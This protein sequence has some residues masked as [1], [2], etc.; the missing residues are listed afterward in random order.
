[1][2]HC[3]NS[4]DFE[5]ETVTEETTNSGRKLGFDGLENDD[6]REVLNAHLE[7]FTDDGLLILDQQRESLKKPTEM[8][9]NEIMCK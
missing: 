7:E 2:P 8:P 3:A 1:L 5:E 6:V 4:S 9:K